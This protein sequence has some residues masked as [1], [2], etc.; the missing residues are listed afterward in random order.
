MSAWAEEF[1]AWFLGCVAT[2]WS[3]DSGGPLLA[4]GASERVA[5]LVVG[6]FKLPDAFGSGLKPTE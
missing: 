6:T 5:Q 4:E 1:R 2:G 3:C